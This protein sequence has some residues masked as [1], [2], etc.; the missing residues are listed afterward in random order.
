VRE[1]GTSGISR[2]RPLMLHTAGG[3]HSGL[4]RAHR[5]R[6]RLGLLAHEEMTP[7]SRHGRGRR[8]RCSHDE[9]VVKAARLVLPSAAQQDIRT[10]P[11]RSDPIRAPP[12]TT[13]PHRLLEE[14]NGPKRRV[15]S[16]QRMHSDCAS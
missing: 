3:S 14:R 2:S 1:R 13:S 7:M 5:S 10:V 6:L 16:A 12:R 8:P 9:D 15:A 4:T 11:H